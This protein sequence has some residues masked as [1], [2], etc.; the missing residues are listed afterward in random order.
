MV[1]AGGDHPVSMPHPGDYDGTGTEVTAVNNLTGKW[2]IVRPFCV[3]GT[4]QPGRSDNVVWV[5]DSKRD[6]GIMTPGY[7]NPPGDRLTGGCGAIENWGGYALD[8]TTRLWT[9]P[10]AAA[11]LPP[12]PDVGWGGDRGA[13]YGTYSV[14][15]DE[16]IRVRQEPF[17]RLEALNLTTKAWRFLALGNWNTQASRAQTVIDQREQQV[18]WIEA[19]STATQPVEGTFITGQAYLVKVD[20]RKGGVTRIPIPSQ[21]KRMEGLATDVYLAFDPGSRQVLIPNNYDMGGSPL[22]GLGFYQVDTGQWAW[23]AVPAEVWGSAWG[24]DESVGALIGIGKRSPPYAT[25]LYKP[26]PSG[27]HPKISK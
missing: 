27:E 3:P 19:W 4:V 6:R 21:Y 1:V 10:D 9:G 22:Q 14:A 26:R 25:F 8:F 24:F 16:M 11:G 2:R 23:E 7:M 12:P 13:S 18:Y 17:L 20:L 15:T 5:Y